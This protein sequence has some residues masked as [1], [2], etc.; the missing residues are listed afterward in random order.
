[1][2]EI[3]TDYPVDG[4]CRL[5]LNRPESLNA[6]TYAMYEQ[7][8]AKLEAIRFDLAV[9]V[10]ILTGAGR[11][12]CAGHDIHVSG[13]PSWVAES[14]GRAQISRAVMTKVAA[15][16]VLLR[17]LPQ[18]VIAAVNGPCAGVG[19]SIALAA[20][21]CIAARS[22]KFAPGF[23]N[24]GSGHELGFSYMLPRLVGFQRAAEII[25]T[26]RTL[27]AEEAAAMG[28]IL[29]MVEDERLG[30]E[31]L[32]I[33]DRIMLNSPIGTA[34]TKQSMWLNANAGSLEAA[35]ELE[36]RGV[37]MSQTTEDT[38][39]KRKATIEKRRPVFTQQ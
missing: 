26:G 17:S 30:D 33:A 15:I 3:E 36:N 13:S 39:E 31:A 5:T 10:I 20:D 18:P 11:G 16:P 32:A 25:L 29:R 38:A 22:A 4:V 28:M 35:I 2:S 21:L 19:Y 14:A 8:L 27:S 23:H 24:V 9:R 12:F 34:I 37:F 6:F 1:V 7:L